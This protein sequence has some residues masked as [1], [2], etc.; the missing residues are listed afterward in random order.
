[1]SSAS[2]S[3]HSR[4]LSPCR[5]ASG[6]SFCGSSSTRCAFSSRA[7]AIG[8]AGTGPATLLVA[9]RQQAP[10]LRL[11]LLIRRPDQLPQQPGCD[12]G[13]LARADLRLQR[14]PHRTWIEVGAA[15]GE[16]VQLLAPQP[17]HPVEHPRRLRHPGPGR[18]PALVRR[19]P[20]RADQ[21]H[22]HQQREQMQRVIDRRQ[23]SILDFPD[24]PG[25]GTV[26]LERFTSDLYLEKR[27]DVR[28]FSAMFD[29]LQAQALNPERTRCFITRAAEDRLAAGA[30]PGR[31]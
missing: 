24:A 14:P 2:T 26:Y 1:M 4:A 7:P 19:P 11:G 31:P 29:H 22:L 18:H 9:G 25:A 16:K 3:S 28:H 6:K 15:L 23:F 5:R 20:R 12:H 17:E 13:L 21:L 8:A 30:L 10:H 27:S